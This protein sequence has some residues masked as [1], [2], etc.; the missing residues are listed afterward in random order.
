MINLWSLK[1]PK[2]RKINNQPESVK[3]KLMLTLIKWNWKWPNIVVTVWQESSQN[4]N[5][6]HSKTTIIFNA[7][8]SLNTFI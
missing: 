6:K 2:K 3:A 5:S 8:D 7:H 1:D 4:I